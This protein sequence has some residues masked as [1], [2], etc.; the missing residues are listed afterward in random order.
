MN[1][2]WLILRTLI[3]NIA[4]IIINIFVWRDKRV[5]LFG[6]W[7]G[8]KFADNS[9][10][11]YQYMFASKEFLN[12]K[13]VVWVTRNNQLYEELIELGYT[14]H[15]MHSIQS[16]FYHF[17]AGVHVV[18]NM[19]AQTGK[20]QGDIMGEF[21]LGAKKIQL[22]HGN[23]IKAVGFATNSYKASSQAKILYHR[24][25]KSKFLG[26]LL[27]PGGWA[28]GNYFL[29]SKSDFDREI[30]RMK[31]ETPDSHFIIASYPRNC[32]CLKYLQREYHV[33]NSFNE[34]SKVILYLPTF[35]D[36]A[37]TFMHPLDN[38][39]LMDFIKEND[40]L[41]IEKP[42]SAA[43]GQV[44]EYE[45]K[46]VILL[47]EKFDINTLTPFMDLLITDYSS[48]AI[49]AMFH[50]VPILY[51][52][53]DYDYYIKNDRG[54]VIDFDKVLIG[55][56]VFNVT[57]LIYYLKQWIQGDVCWKFEYEEIRD[58]FWEYQDYD[59]EQIVM[60]VMD[61]LH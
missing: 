57:Q 56:K 37:N 1:R 8:N 31:F 44:R 50:K 48:V 17:R 60:A 13:K 51:F 46:N 6:S 53:P 10:Y 21:S 54:F 27:T 41:W 5:W 47:N 61:K 36:K 14:C 39:E 42:H 45:S 16:I 4:T 3:C 55:E 28:N 49:D 19:Y 7:M 9:R 52:V 23:G 32:K 29:L 11:L 58:L 43:E 22:W 38:Y 26:K 40:L 30:F 15:K 24:I 35:R 12:L 20:Y 34:F 59:Y 25:L 33:I 2:L 18:C